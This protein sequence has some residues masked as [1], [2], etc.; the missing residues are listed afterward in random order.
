MAIFRTPDYNRGYFETGDLSSP[1]PA[2][3]PPLRAAAAREERKVTVDPERIRKYEEAKFKREEAQRHQ[4]A[5]HV[6][7]AKPKRRYN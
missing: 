4:T 2:R 3:D 1:D 5:K 7:W 6:P